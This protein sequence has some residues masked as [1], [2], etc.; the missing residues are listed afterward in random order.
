MLTLWTFHCAI[1]NDDVT[2]LIPMLE[3]KCNLGKGKTRVENRF[4][5]IRQKKKTTWKRSCVP[6]WRK[7]RNTVA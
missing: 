2:K 1:F 6:E 4:Q 3:Q 5:I 7:P